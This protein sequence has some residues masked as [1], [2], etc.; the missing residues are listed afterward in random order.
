MKPFILSLTQIALL[1]G[2]GSAAAQAHP[3]ATPTPVTTDAAVSQAS[4]EQRFQ[5]ARELAI[6]GKRDEAIAAYSQ[7]LEA[8]P[9]NADVLLGR[10]RVYAWMGQWQEAE[11]DLR[12][13]T[14]TAPNY[15]D[16][17]AALGDMYL[18]SDRPTQAADAY[19][20]WIALNPT[21]PAPHVARGRALRAAGD[22]TA[23]RAEFEAAGVNGADAAQVDSY[24]QSLM[25]RVQNPEV[26]VPAGYHWS[27]SLAASRTWF[28][29]SRNPWGEYTAS[30]RRH[31]EHGSL[32]VELLDARRFGTSDR[33]WALDG[34]VDLWSR[35]YANLRYQHGPRGD[36]Y[37][38]NAWRA[39]LFQ[40]VGH[41]W[42]LSGSYDRL[43]FT[44]SNVDM[45]GIGVGKYVGN[46]YL[47]A[48]TLYIPGDGG[49]STSFRGQVRY[50]YAGDGD[51]YVEFNAGS[52]R[53]RD[54][55]S[56]NPGVVGRNRSSSA[57]VAFVKYPSPRW[58]FKIGVGYGDDADSFVERGIYGALYRRW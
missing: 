8:S 44:N 33:A 6:S 49:H 42:E 20:R 15:A 13:V 32:A 2:A 41:G 27:A 39:E 12:S 37:P 52:G 19:G 18:W 24:L 29:P 22:Y 50:Y 14:T 35:A 57:S 54:L 7:L 4:Y 31:F 55:L 47:R 53:S 16:A 26:V 46:F 45:Y 40:G 10:G 21:D 51:N 28:S 38:G 17:W 11:A 48:R 58:G 30:L 56:G 5:A 3:D 36:L 25:P 23:A 9:G 43:D 34:Y 1:A